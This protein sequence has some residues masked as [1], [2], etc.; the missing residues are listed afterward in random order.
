VQ[1]RLLQAWRLTLTGLGLVL[2]AVGL[3]GLALPTHLLGF[4]FV[5]GLMLVLRSS[6]RWRRR[7][8]RLQRRHP[9]W[10]YPFRRLMRGEVWPV[11]WHELLRTERWI[12]PRRW[13][14]LRRW[15]AAGRLRRRRGAI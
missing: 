3:V 13:R 7:F 15:R 9:R 6:M 2:M 4:L 14:R 10:V 1:R 8:I 5:F 11:I 12:L